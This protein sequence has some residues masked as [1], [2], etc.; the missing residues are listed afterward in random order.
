LLEAVEGAGLG[1]G[2]EGGEG[3]ELDKLAAGGAD[4]EV[5]QLI[6]GEAGGALGLG[7]DFVTAAAVTEPVDIVAAE[8]GAEIGADL[9]EVYAQHGHFVAVENDFGLGL[10]VFQVG[11][12]EHELFACEGFLYE[13]VC[14][15][16]NLAG[17]GGGVDDEVDGELAAAGEG[18]GGGGDDADAGDGAYFS[19][20]FADDLLG[21]T[22][23]VA[24]G[25]GDH[26]GE[27]EGGIGD[28]E[29]FGGLR[30]GFEDVVDFLCVAAGLVDGG[31]GGGLDDAEDDAL[32]FLGGEFLRGQEIEGDG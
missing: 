10:V 2:L 26:A 6:D 31:V 18:F 20:D 17:L 23:A 3:G 25:F 32:V 19:K 12:G 22:G 21:G 16:V 14:E 7:D 29:G 30:E 4:V 9:G 8:E 5:F 24:P 13:L 15:V 11:V 28:L 27:A 1:G